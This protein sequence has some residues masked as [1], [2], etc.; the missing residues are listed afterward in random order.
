VAQPALRGRIDPR[1]FD[2]RPPAAAIAELGVGVKELELTTVGD[3]AVYIATLTGGDTRIV[4]LDGEPFD[5]FSTAALLSIVMQSVEPVQITESRL[6]DEYDRYYLDRHR[7]RPLPAL[8]A[9]L[10]DADETRFYIDPKTARVAGTYSAR[11][12]RSRYLYHGLHSLDFPWLYDH[13]PAWDIVVLT[14]MVGGTALC[15]TSVI[16]AWRVVKPVHTRDSAVRA[17]ADT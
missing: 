17:G 5:A 1:A 10:N 14:F 2:A 12:W 13:R 8:L 16:L 6:I 3:R 7:A 15:V 9:V 4:P 11:R